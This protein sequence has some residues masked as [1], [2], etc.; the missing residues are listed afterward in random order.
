[1]IEGNIGLYKR[2]VVESWAK[3]QKIPCH[4]I[5]RAYCSF[6]LLSDTIE[7]IKQGKMKGFIL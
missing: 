1:M 3:K 5:V 6:E 2:K 4:Q 7:D